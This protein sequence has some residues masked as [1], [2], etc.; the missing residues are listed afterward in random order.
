MRYAAIWKKPAQFSLFLVIGVFLTNPSFAE[1]N[2]RDTTLQLE[3]VQR[4]TTAINQIKNYYVDPVDDQALFE[5]AIRGMLDGLDPHSSYLNI[6]DY[7]ELHDQTQGSFGGLGIE[8]GLEDGYIRVI[9]P[10]DDTPAKRA[11]IQPGDLIVRLDKKPVKG[12]SLKDAVNMMRGKPG[13]SI[14]LTILR[15]SEERLLQISVARDIIKIESVKS[16][17]LEP[18]YGYVRISHFQSPT[19]SNL[20][21]AINQLQKES[22]NQLKGVILDLRNNPG[23]LL[24][25]AIEVSD[26]FLDSKKLD[27]NDL[28]VFTKGRIP[29]TELIAK[30]SPGDLLNSLPM[31]VLIN[32]GSASGSEIVA[33]AL[34]DHKRAVIMGTTSF[35]KGSV[36][37]VFPLDEQ[38]GLKLTTAL[39]YT[40]NGRSIQATGIEP[41]ILVENMTVNVDKKTDDMVLTLLKEADLDHHLKNTQKQAA[42][43]ATATKA[44]DDDDNQPLV[45]KDYQLN[46]ALNLLKGL[47]VANSF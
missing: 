45:V 35:G 24:D 25:S 30:A 47:H 43:T 21:K 3:D 4:F 36:Q 31:V 32:E 38:R 34:Q 13:T 33:G 9:S 16:R 6:E 8:V 37:T 14:D 12:M 42:N 23:G 10:I 5:H 44:K 46:E 26:V 2:N 27:K 20:I 19:G 28:I 40:P 22:N 41:D 7:A 39:Y 18:N 11:G 17:Q 15:R 1:E 29:G